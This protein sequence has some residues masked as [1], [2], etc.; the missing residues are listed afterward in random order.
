MSG[1]LKPV[2]GRECGECTMCCKLFAIP[3]LGKGEGVWC[4]H[5]TIGTGCQ[6]YEQRPQEC[7]DFFCH[8][9]LDTDVPERWKP[10]RSHMVL[11]SDADGVR[12]IVH[13]D[14]KRPQA[15]RADPYYRDLKAWALNRLQADKQVHV[16]IGTRTII[17]LPDRDVDLGT[18]GDDKAILTHK[19]WT[20]HGP[21]FD[22]E[23]VAKNDPRVR[24]AAPGVLFRQR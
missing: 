7:R 13:V 3:S 4:S 9:R 21:R 8:Y 16:R 2:A 19:Q 15:W 22:F 23:L 1:A 24:P 5:C 10:D 12:I 20:P 14:P 17:I 11:V 6:I 18:V